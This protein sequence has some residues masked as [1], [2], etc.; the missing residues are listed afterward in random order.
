MDS[1]ASRSATRRLDRQRLHS[2]MQREQKKFVDDRPKSRAL[3]ERACK[4]LL[5]GV[6]MNWMMKWAGAFPPFVRE[7]QGA[8]FFDVDGHR[9]V[10]FCLGDTGAMTGHSPSATVTAVQQQLARGITLMLPSEDSIW[11]GEELQKR[12]GLPFWQFALTATDANRFSIR[13]A[14]HITGRPK[15]LVFNWCY[16]GTV[17]E[18]FIT[19]QDGV[20]G[21]R[22]GNIGPPVDP[23]VTTKVIEF[24]DVDALERALQAKDVA[25]VLAEPALTNV[26]IVLPA[27]GFHQAL[28]DLTRKYGTLLIIDE[29]HT[30]CAGPG[31]YTRAE[32]LNPDFLVFGK[33]IGGGVPGATYGFSDEVAKMISERQA[34]EDCDTGGIGGTL[35]GN[36]LS[37]AA[38]KATLQKVLNKEAFDRMIP[39]AQRWTTGVHKAIT[40]F[41]IPWNVTRLGC[42]A[43]YLFSPSEPRNGSEAHDAMDFELERFMHLYAMN[44]GI[45]LTPFHN[46][47]LMSPVTEADDVDRHS[48]VFREA[49]KELFA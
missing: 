43:E 37:I 28:R 12:F 39:L 45:L 14:R 15:I 49:V 34:L 29:T 20:S 6:P 42:R 35:A 27:P 36:A 44:R 16:H 11:V 48:K 24:N 26:G 4:S 8:H 31:G 22:R 18:T 10:D 38:M 32:N 23:T 9:Y 40:E 17:D 30:I 19:L 41:G 46:M 21:A 33:P 2:L 25:C 5:G 47:A 13:L 3:Y 7:A 1:V